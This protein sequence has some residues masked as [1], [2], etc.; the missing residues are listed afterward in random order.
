MRAAGERGETLLELIVAV[1]I[2]GVAFVAVLGGIGTSIL[3]SDIHRKQATAG[4]AVRN[5]AEA[6][7]NA[8]AAS[9][10]GYQESCTPTFAFTPPAG[11]EASITAVSFWNGS[12]FP[13]G[14]CTVGTVGVQKVS[15]QVK[16]SDER[17]VETL[18]VIVRRPC[19]AIADF[20]LD[21][22]CA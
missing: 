18:E 9:P 15:L 19:R 4:A 6:V 16:S 20:P 7:E 11:Y 3:M 12:S 14:P 5:Y 1:A 13:A 8:V 22:P 17:A 21:T 2:M 10:S